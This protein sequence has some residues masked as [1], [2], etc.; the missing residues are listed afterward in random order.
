MDTIYATTVT[1]RTTT[2]EL[3]NGATAVLPDALD[4]YTDVK[5]LQLPDGGYRIGWLDWDEASDWWPLDR[6]EPGEVRELEPTNY[7]YGPDEVTM[8]DARGWIESVGIGNGR[9]VFL[10]DEEGHIGRDWTNMRPRWIYTAPEDVPADQREQYAEG[11]WS[12]WRAWARGENYGAVWVDVDA[13]GT[14]R[15][16]TYDSVWGLIGDDY[17]AEALAEYMGVPTELVAS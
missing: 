10:V 17:A 3:P 16:G 15:D 4:D 2:V 1:T 12:E 8:D 7:R 6:C 11:V 5:V 14:V 9:R 13:D